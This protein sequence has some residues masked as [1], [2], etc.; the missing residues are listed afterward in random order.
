M[1][2]LRGAVLHH[3]PLAESRAALQDLTRLL[4]PGIPNEKGQKHCF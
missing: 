1:V 4:R 2:S 3:L